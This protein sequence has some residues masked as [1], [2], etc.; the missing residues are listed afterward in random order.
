VADRF[1]GGDVV[2]VTHEIPI[3]VLLASILALEG[4]R[5]WE[6]D[7]PTGSIAGLLVDEDAVSVLRMPAAPGLSR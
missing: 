6:L 3:R 5:L 2:V 1:P 7:V 4:S